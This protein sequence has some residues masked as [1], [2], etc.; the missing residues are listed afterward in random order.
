MGVRGQA[1]A[2]LLASHLASE[3]LS[4]T[5]HPCEHQATQSLSFSGCSCQPPLVA[6]A[7][8]L[9]TCAITSDFTWVVEIVGI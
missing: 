4:L 8:G 2:L 3:A 5:V 7:L 9:H 1:Q 6:G